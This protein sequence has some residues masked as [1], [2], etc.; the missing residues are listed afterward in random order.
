MFSWHYQGRKWICWQPLK[1]PPL[2]LCWY[3]FLLGISLKNINGNVTMLLACVGPD[4]IDT[5]PAEGILAFSYLQ[6]VFNWKFEICLSRITLIWSN[7]PLPLNF[8]IF[9]GRLLK[10]YLEM[11][12][13]ILCLDIGVLISFINN[14]SLGVFFW[15]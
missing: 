7:T 14:L 2:A 1:C 8:C 6:W 5:T 13:L 15:K 9:V 4:N 11:C 10:F 3:L 12:C